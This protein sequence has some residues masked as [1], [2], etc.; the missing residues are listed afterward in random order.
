M[1]LVVVGVGSNHKWRW[2]IWLCVYLFIYLFFCCPFS[3]SC[4]PSRLLARTHATVTIV[5]LLLV[6]WL[7]RSD[8]V[9]ALGYKY[10]YL[11]M[12]NVFVWDR[13]SKIKANLLNLLT[14]CVTYE[15]ITDRPANKVIHAQGTEGSFRGKYDLK[16]R[17]GITKISR[18]Y[19]AASAFFLFVH[20]IIV[21]S[22][23]EIFFSH[24]L[25]TNS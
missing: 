3:L 13:I 14:T 12:S 23:Q 7:I 15:R 21:C 5:F 4:F 2:S 6:G 20:F 18:H 19:F 16:W 25:L 11:V 17:P 1:L 22:M 8:F 10:K 24:I 9:F